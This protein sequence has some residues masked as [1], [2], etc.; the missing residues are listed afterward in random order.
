MYSYKQ[1][2]GTLFSLPIELLAR[3]SEHFSRLMKIRTSQPLAGTADTHAIPVGPTDIEGVE[4][5]TK[6][7]F[8]NLL[9]WLLGKSWQVPFRSLCQ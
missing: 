5:I 9:P 2:E 1:V 4:V 6:D 8:Q 3:R 7:Q